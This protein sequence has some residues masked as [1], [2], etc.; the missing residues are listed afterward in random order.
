MATKKILLVDDEP[1]MRDL[2]LYHFGQEGHEVTAVENGRRAVE[3]LGEK[4]FDVV[5]MDIHMPEMTGPEALKIIKKRKPTQTVVM[6]SSSSDPDY[7]LERQS[8]ELGAARWLPKPF[9]ID[10]IHEILTGS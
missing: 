6:L 8:E 5:F 7:L 4:A 3:V 2:F 10:V 9:D 1:G